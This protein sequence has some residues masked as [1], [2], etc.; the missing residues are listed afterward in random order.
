[1]KTERFDDIVDEM[2]ITDNSLSFTLRNMGCA[3]DAAQIL[4]IMCVPFHL[5]TKVLESAS[6][7]RFRAPSYALGILRNL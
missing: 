4:A 2:S 5:D 6:E 1:M 3:A 7:W